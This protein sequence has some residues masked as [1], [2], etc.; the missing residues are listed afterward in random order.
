[1][2]KRERVPTP[3]NG[4]IGSRES[5]CNGRF[6]GLLAL[7]S[8][9]SIKRGGRGE[10]QTWEHYTIQ[11]WIRPLHNWSKCSE[12]TKISQPEQSPQL[13]RGV[14]STGKSHPDRQKI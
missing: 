6:I 4:D 11:E 7:D 8:T 10:P 12:E 13:F 14:D 1:M 3:C 5:E 9:L 2:K